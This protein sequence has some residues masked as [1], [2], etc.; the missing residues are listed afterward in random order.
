MSAV[1]LWLS[2]V[3]ACGMIVCACDAG[4]APRAAVDPAGVLQSA[5]SAPGLRTTFYPTM[6]LCV[7]RGEGR[8]RKSVGKELLSVHVCVLMLCSLVEA[9]VK[10]ER[11]RERATRS[12]F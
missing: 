6:H 3:Q 12:F 8:D 10:G 2:N 4:E 7:W 1:A 5:C 9:S 11:D